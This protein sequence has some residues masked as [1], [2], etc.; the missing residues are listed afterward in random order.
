MLIIT[1]LSIALVFLHPI[2][3]QVSKTFFNTLLA[4]CFL[5][6][7]GCKTD[8]LGDLKQNK[9]PETHSI[10]DSIFRVG[11]D[12]FTTKVDIR[13]WGDDF[14]GF[15]TGYEFT[16]DKTITSSTNWIYT[17]VSDSVFTLVVPAGSDTSDFDFWVRSIDNEGLRDLTPAH[18]TYPVR[19][20]PPTVSFLT[21][22]DKGNPLAGGNPTVS[23]P[24]LRYN[25]LATDPDGTENIARIEIVLNDTAATPYSLT[26]SV[27]SIIIYAE[28]LNTAVTSCKVYQGNNTSAL[29]ERLQG[30]KLADTNRLY[31]RV[32]DLSGAKSPW[33]SSNQIFVKK[34]RYPVLLVNAYSTNPTSVFDFY[35]TKMQA[36]GL[37]NFE[38][39]ELFKNESGQYTRLAPDNR[40]QS[41]IFNLFKNI[42]YYAPDFELSATYLSG[43]LGSF[44]NAGGNLFYSA[45][46][47]STAQQTSSFYEF[48]SVD[49]LLSPA[50]NYRFVMTDTSQVI[51][52][53]SGYPT[54]KYTG[55]LPVVRPVKFSGGS[56]VL[57]KANITLQQISPLQF[58]PYAGVSDILGIRTN[59]VSG[60]KTA[61]TTLELHKL[62]GNNNAHLLL[63]KILKGEFGL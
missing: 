55:F 51:P 13:W 37:P 50:A 26:S 27:N 46:A 48:A 28:N 23:Y 61:V 10:V 45:Y 54:V 2:Y 24:V 12:R 33:K 59:T 35:N 31:I 6:I 22:P 15:V 40:T 25:W 20:S 42:V 49:S 36:I 60:S 38:T 21:N 3:F 9:A 43:T 19:N 4:S 17:T 57:A 58:T 34:V 44:L 63:E 7:A 41:L 62:D 5:L 56:T 29:P 32:I 47:T 30:L 16:F 1:E 39:L 8:I 53:V 52:L 14:D 11:Q 18:V